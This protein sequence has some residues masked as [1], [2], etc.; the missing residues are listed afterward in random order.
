MRPEPAITP[1][2]LADGPA[3]GDRFV[4]VLGA[5]RSD[6]WISVD[7]LFGS[8]LP[9][10]LAMVAAARGANSMAVAGALLFEQFANRMTAPVLAVLLREGRLLDPRSPRVRAQITRGALVRLA[11]TDPPAARD[12]TTQLRTETVNA[13]VTAF[14]SPA[15]A[16]RRHTRLGTRALQGAMANALASTLLHLSWP[17]EDR[18]RYVADARA[19]LGDV[20]GWTGLVN[21]DA[22]ERGGEQ[23]MYT[24]RNTCCL[25]FRTSVNQA[26]EQR[27]CGTCPAIPRATT[28][29]LFTH[30][31]AAYAAR[32]PRHHV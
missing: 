28:A 2:V 18:A 32:H 20:P 29:E 30:A 6:G 14:T 16:L 10:I 23:W 22:V 31:T 5:P 24:D 26:R 4:A 13:L 15:E 25:A 19:L 27:Y 12:D 9:D 11:F 8:Q 3:L 17:G 21:V 7:T 1:E